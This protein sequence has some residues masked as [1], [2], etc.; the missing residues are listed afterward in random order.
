[1]HP[2]ASKVKYEL[3]KETGLLY[4]DRILASSV[5]YPHNY[6]FIPQTLCEDN[7]PLDVLVL[8]QCPVRGGKAGQ[9]CAGWLGS[10]GEASKVAHAVPGEHRGAR[11][12][13]RAREAGQKQEGTA[14]GGRLGTV[15]G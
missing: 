4:V 8:M 1:L 9:V 14:A 2:Q 3:D 5:R 11:G 7:D 15:P 6:G 12:G 13:R 10:G